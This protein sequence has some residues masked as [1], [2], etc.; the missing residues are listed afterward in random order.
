MNSQTDLLP[1]RL[2]SSVS[3]AYHRYR[4]GQWVRIPLKPQIFFWA[5]FVTASVTSDCEDHF[6]FYFL[7]AV[8][9]CDIYHIN[10][11]K[12]NNSR[13]KQI[14]HG[15]INSVTSKAN[16]S[17]QKQINSERN[18]FIVEDSLFSKGCYSSQQGI[19]HP[20]CFLLN[21]A[22]RVTANIVYFKMKANT[23]TSS[24]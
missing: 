17:Q 6:H 8:H 21:L 16:R 24:G 19:G 23:R 14:N 7:S 20:S 4:G 12:A 1:W 18:I 22:S 3:R 13:K 10:F 15:K 11:T 2:H 5:F 9:S